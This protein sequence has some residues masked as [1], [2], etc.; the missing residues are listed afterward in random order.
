MKAANGEVRSAPRLNWRTRVAPK[1]LRQDGR[2]IILLLIALMIALAAW[3]GKARE[4]EAME[5]ALAKANAL[6]ERT[7]AEYDR[8]Y[9]DSREM[10]Q[11]IELAPWLKLEWELKHDPDQVRGVDGKHPRERL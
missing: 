2:A 10:A 11:F 1:A 3:H 4:V 6:L 9:E 8:L 7:N 5:A